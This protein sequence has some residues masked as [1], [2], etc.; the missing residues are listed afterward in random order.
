MIE[1]TIYAYPFRLKRL[2]FVN[3]NY[4]NELVKCLKDVLRKFNYHI[5]P[6]FIMRIEEFRKYISDEE[7]EEKYGGNLPDLN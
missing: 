4:N 5:K 6:E 2:F 7:R 3:A 1:K